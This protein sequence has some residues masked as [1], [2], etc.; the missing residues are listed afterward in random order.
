MTQLFNTKISLVAQA[1]TITILSAP[2]MAK[3]I[4]DKLTVA[5]GYNV[6]LFAD[7]VENA[8]E[9]A[10]SDTGIVYVGSIRA[11]NVYALIDKDNDGVADEKI[12]IASGLTMPSG[13][14]YK[15][16]NLYVSEVE[17]IIRFKNIDKNL[18]T[19]QYDVVFDKF[20]SDTHHGWKVLGFSPTGELII[21]VG[22][23]CNV[24][25]ENERYGRIFSLDLKTKKLT[26]IA[27]GVRN[28]VG[29]DFHPKTNTFWFSDN[30]R[31]MM[32]D[33]IPPCE[34]NK[35]SYQ[36]E[37]FGFPYVHA[38]TILDPEFGK[39]KNTKDYTAPALSLG[40]HVAPL[41]I[42]FYRGQQF[43]KAYQEQL[44]VAEHGS[45]NRSKKAGYKVA[46]ATIE[47]GEIIKYSPFITGF[48]Q[49]EETFG[50]PVAFAELADGSLLISD[51][52][53]GA[54][55]RVTKNK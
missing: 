27:Q 13:V 26:T 22:V 46:V 6:S 47:D 32:G 30:G 53:A 48:M 11:G 33:D 39:G 35:V 2:V 45:W 38:G 19:P 55:Y 14:A 49:N 9:L 51:D 44:F 37:H 34:I 29:F 54:I 28:S 43:P 40:A 24:C 23:P 18:N 10:I 3:D 31:D 17:R 5:D 20:P 25:A 50:R 15:D 21:P 36:G 52:F 41:G 8:R 4:L 1:L 16:G 7:D 12:V 42:H